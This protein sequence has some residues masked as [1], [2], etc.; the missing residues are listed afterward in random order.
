M[1]EKT[2][3]LYK[4]DKR[5]SVRYF[6]VIARRIEDGAVL[7]TQKGLL[8]QSEQEDIEP[9]YPKN[10]GRANE[11]QPYQQAVLRADSAVN[12][13]FDKGYKLLG[14]EEVIE[15]YPLST[16]EEE[17]IRLRGTDANNHPLPMLAQKT[18]Y[19]EPRAELPGFVQRKFDGVRGLAQ[20]F[21]GVSTMRSRKGKPF[22]NLDHI[23][24]D[25]PELPPG[26]FYDGE[27]YSHELSLQQIVSRVKREQEENKL[28]L[29]R[30]YDLGGTDLTYAKR[31][32]KLHHLLKHAGPSVHRVRTYRVRSFGDIAQYFKRFKDEGY[33]GAIYRNPDFEYEQ[34]ERSYG[35]IKVKDFLE[36]EFEV[37]GAEE[38][39][40][41]DVGTAIFICKTKKG[42]EF[43]VR[44][45]GSREV[46]REY[47]ENI[48][49]LIGKMLTV[50]F[51]QW[52]DEGKPFHTRGVVIRDY[53]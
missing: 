1:E 20:W 48:E 34:G 11:T 38:A 3:I 24:D 8:G 7:I 43:K 13:L 4:L 49:D 19:L 41:R 33:E 53:E 40:G 15:K 45:M 35:L 26:W 2:R 27:L 16:L 22:L 14:K 42:L 25:L 50:R 12:K 44:P 29:Y 18:K 5:G 31:K 37:I 36:E 30:V 32:K 51:Q 39:T 52:T 23:L 28:I 6:R 46:R 21:S 47:L 9:I 17:L 10:V